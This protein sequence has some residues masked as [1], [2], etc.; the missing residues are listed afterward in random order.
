MDDSV[1][2]RQFERRDGSGTYIQLITPDS[3]HK[4]VLHLSHE[5]RL[6]GHLGMHRTRER[7]IQNFYWFEVR[8][9][10]DLYVTVCDICQSIKRPIKTPK[11]R[12]G[13]M[14]VGGPL[15]RLSIDILGL[16]PLSKRGI[17]T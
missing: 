9:D 13:E 3:L 15:D 2:Y 4:E 1:L 17:S 5:N 12:L 14:P 16:L 10:C 6:S 11:A 7:L 8:T